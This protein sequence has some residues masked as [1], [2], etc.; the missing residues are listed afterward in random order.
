MLEED[1]V[2]LGECEQI[3]VSETGERV[4][5]K[6]LIRGSLWMEVWFDDPTDR[7]PNRTIRQVANA[8]RLPFDRYIEP[9]W[10]RL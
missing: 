3:A 6:L 2:T 10:R 1:G 9:N 8:L 5:A 4:Q 7:V